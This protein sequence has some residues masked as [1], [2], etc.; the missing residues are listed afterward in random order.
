[1]NPSVVEGE[2]K[3]LSFKDAWIMTEWNC[4]RNKCVCPISILLCY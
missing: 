4:W 1:M 2:K 3:W